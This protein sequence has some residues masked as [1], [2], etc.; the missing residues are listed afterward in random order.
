MVPRHKRL[1]LEMRDLRNRYGD[2]QVTCRNQVVFVLTDSAR[3]FTFALADDYPF[4][5]P[6]VVHDGRLKAP[7]GW[8]PNCDMLDILEQRIEI[9]PAAAQYSPKEL[10]THL[11]HAVGT[12]DILLLLTNEAVRGR[13]RVQKAKH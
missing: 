7:T 2:G 8:L 6:L 3:H 10:R 12:D 11:F 13:G 4:V 1:P 9:R 5:P